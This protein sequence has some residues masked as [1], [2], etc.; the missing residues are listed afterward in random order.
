MEVYEN[1]AFSIL[2]LL[3]KERYSS[4]FK[5]GFR[6]HKICFKVKPQALKS[7]VPLF[8]RIYA[9]SLALK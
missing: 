9:V 8:R 2:V 4:F 3:T 1:D 7:L 5:K 6:F